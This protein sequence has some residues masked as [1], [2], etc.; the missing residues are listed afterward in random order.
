VRI[1]HEVLD[2]EG[3]IVVWRGSVDHVGTGRRLYFNDLSTVVRFIQERVGLP[4][5]P[6]SW[7]KSM[8]AWV[9][10]ESR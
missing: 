10:H 6:R 5:R 3:K 1:W 9:R 8:L 7:W 4:T 2:E